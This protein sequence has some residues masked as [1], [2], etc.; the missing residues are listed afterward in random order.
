MCK[1]S[2]LINFNCQVNTAQ[3]NLKGGAIEEL[4]R[5]DSPV[6]MSAGVVLVVKLCKKGRSTVN[7][8]TFGSLRLYKKA[9]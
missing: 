1:R 4:S 9:R 5:S 7:S 8:I 3:I 6:S 2:V